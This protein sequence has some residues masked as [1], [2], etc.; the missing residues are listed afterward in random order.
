MGTCYKERDAS[1]VWSR[2]LVPAKQAC[3]LFSSWSLLPRSL[4]S[5]RLMFPF[6]FAFILA[7]GIPFLPSS[8]HRALHLPSLRSNFLS[9]S[10]APER[11]LVPSSER[12]PLL[13]NGYSRY[14]SDSGDSSRYLIFTSPSYSDHEVD[15][16]V[17]AYMSF[18][19][20]LELTYP[21][22]SIWL[23]ICAP[24]LYKLVEAMVLM[25]L[26]FFFASTFLSRRSLSTLIERSCTAGFICRHYT[27]KAAL[28]SFLPDVLLCVH[29]YWMDNSVTSDHAS[30]TSTNF[31][32]HV[33]LG[34]LADGI[35]STATISEG[36]DLVSTKESN[37]LS[38]NSSSV[39]LI[40]PPRSRETSAPLEPDLIALRQPVDPLSTSSQG[41][42]VKPIL[43]PTREPSMNVGSHPPGSTTELSQHEQPSAVLGAPVEHHLRSTLSSATTGAKNDNTD[44]STSNSKAATHEVPASLNRSSTPTFVTISLQDMYRA[45]KPDSTSISHSALPSDGPENKAPDAI[46]GSSSDHGS[47]T[48]VDSSPSKPEPGEVQAE[49]LRSSSSER[50]CSGHRRYKSDGIQVRSASCHLGGLA[51]P[52]DPATVNGTCVFWKS[53]VRNDEK[54]GGAP[55]ERALAPGFPCGSPSVKRTGRSMPGQTV[56]AGSADVVLAGMVLTPEGEIL[57]PAS[58]R[59]DG[60]CISHFHLASCDSY[61]AVFAACARRLKS[62]LAIS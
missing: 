9:A 39:P 41:T 11:S 21:Q 19:E 7:I 34:V 27:P 60:R 31:S 3:I 15:S 56:D 28:S 20:K 25:T 50:P 59:A 26:S 30:T 22:T 48:N 29:K 35:L 58:Q 47:I 55:E 42:Q 13:E 2:C 43:P 4:P 46:S 17:F 23:V 12:S 45:K 62:A 5:T 54:G 44:V 61:G 14:N 57:V 32:Q 53:T 33:L 16:D 8:L 51:A 38:E 49:G 6:I 52:P 36:L 18:T 10:Y 40:T 24:L 1:V 37:C